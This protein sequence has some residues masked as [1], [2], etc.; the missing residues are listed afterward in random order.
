MLGLCRFV[1]VIVLMVAF[2]IR[3]RGGLFKGHTP[4]QLPPAV[5]PNNNADN[6]DSDDSDSDNDSDS[7]DNDNND[8][9]DPIII[10]V[11]DLTENDI[12]VICQEDCESGDDTFTACH[13]HFHHECI[14]HWAMVQYSSTGLDPTCPLC[15]AA[16][17]RLN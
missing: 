5:Q 16:L 7:D 11:V 10:E 14:V 8:G 1:Y 3:Q 6:D 13:H 15:N 9:D 4:G 17:Y 12:C 2:R